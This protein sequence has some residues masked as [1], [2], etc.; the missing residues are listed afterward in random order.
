MINHS[1]S[2]GGPLSE[3]WEEGEKWPGKPDTQKCS[4][5]HLGNN[6]NLRAHWTPF[7]RTYQNH[8]YAAVL[9][10]LPVRDKT[11]NIFQTY[12]T[13]DLFFL[14]DQCE[15]PGCHHSTFREMWLQMPLVSWEVAWWIG[16]MKG[17]VLPCKGV[18]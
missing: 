14:V 11:H 9:G 5:V 10:G 2:T 15:R 8:S 12:W 4:H 1:L 16:K 3:D 17:L 13:T 6:N 18:R 7:C